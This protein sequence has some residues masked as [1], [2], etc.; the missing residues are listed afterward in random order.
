MR[1]TRF[2]QVNIPDYVA[3]ASL[4]AIAKATSV[5]VRVQVRN[6]G[7]VSVYLSDATGDLVAPGGPSGN[8]YELPT[9]ER[10]VFVIAPGQTMYAV[11][12]GAGGF[13]FVS[14]SDARPV[15]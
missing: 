2:Y 11:A 14:V 9:G 6:A 7:P 1:P 4:P 3:G 13:L 10:D 8:I 15:A 12:A 5:P